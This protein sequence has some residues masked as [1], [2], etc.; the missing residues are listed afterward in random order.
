MIGV[1]VIAV[2]AVVTAAVVTTGG[3]A[4][5]VLATA[6]KLALTGLKIAA[7]TGLVAGTV[8]AGK[9]IC[10]GETD[11]GEIGK[12]FVTGFADGF[13]AGSFYTGGAMVGSAI[14]YTI[15]GIFNKGYGWRSG[16]WEG[17]YQTP[18]TPGIS[19]ATNHGGVNGGR[20]FGLDLDVYNG[21]HYHTNKF[22]IG[23]K[24]NWIKA[25][26]WAD[27]PILIGLGVG[28]SDGWSEW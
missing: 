2:A 16:T 20:S 9:S 27:V 1:A 21:L 7:T 15:S 4:A 3:G 28:L 19:I 24:S 25:H 10:E 22:G 26:H 12:D 13:L 18:N 14:S 5:A 8:R 23:P 6:G 11:I 17:G